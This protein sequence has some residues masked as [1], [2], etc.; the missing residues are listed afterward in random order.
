MTGGE[1]NTKAQGHKGHEVQR[2]FGFFDGLEPALPPSAVARNFPRSIPYEQA[3]RYTSG[4]V[5]I[6]KTSF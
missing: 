6:S 1:F 4:K 2:V 3:Q 5:P